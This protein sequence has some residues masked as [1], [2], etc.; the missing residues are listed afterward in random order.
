[1]FPWTWG[2]KIEHRAVDDGDVGLGQGFGKAVA[3]QSPLNERLGR[4]R[5]RGGIEHALAHPQL[6]TKRRDG[7]GVSPPIRLAD[8]YGRLR[9]VLGRSGC[10][11]DEVALVV[12]EVIW[13]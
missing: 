7:E 2:I 1:M 4:R 12:A 6:A 9:H 13:P 5:A 11:A 10:R 3:R 8:R